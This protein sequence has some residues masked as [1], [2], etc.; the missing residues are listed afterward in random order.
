MNEIYQIYMKEIPVDRDRKPVGNISGIVKNYGNKLLGFIRG[1][2]KSS[3]DAEDILQDVWYQ[4]SN[5][6]NLD[7]IES[8]SGWL[9]R[10]A[11]NKVIDKYR[12]KPTDY[13]EDFIFEDANGNV[14]VKDILLSEF[15]DPAQEELKNLFWDALMQALD[16]LP[17][18]QR[19]VFVKNELEEKTLQEIAAETNENIKT[20]ISRKGY[21][22]KHLRKRLQELYNEFIKDGYEL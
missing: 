22:V 2:V 8:I 1:K 4:L 16:E 13:M 18:N 5:T 21:A 20:I 3:E 19:Y 14:S 6:I 9:Y 12:K 15:T 10:V 11:K 7:E 17:E